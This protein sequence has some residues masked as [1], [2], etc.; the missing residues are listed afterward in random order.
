MLPTMHAV[1]SANN[2]ILTI[3]LA[4]IYSQSMNGHSNDRTRTYSTTYSIVLQ[5]FYSYTSS[6]KIPSDYLDSTG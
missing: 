2:F 1:Y 3:Y 6:F 4:A 5:H